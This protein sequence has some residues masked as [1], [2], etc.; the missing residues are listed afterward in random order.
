MQLG[1]I[2]QE[3]PNPIGAIGDYYEA[4]Y[5]TRTGAFEESE[6]NLEHALIYAP[7]S[8]KAKSL[9]ALSGLEERRNNFD[10]AVKLRIEASLLNNPQ[11]TLESQLGIAALMGI[12]GD[13]RY[14]AKHL[15]RFLPLAYAIGPSPVYFDF[16][17]SYA[18]ELS[19]TE[20]LQEAS[21]V[22]NKVI[23]SPYLSHFP[24]WPETEREIKQKCYSSKSIQA[25]LLLDEA[26]DNVLEFPHL[27]D[28][29]KL[30]RESE[31]RFSA[32]M[33]RFSAL[34]D[35]CQLHDFVDSILIGDMAPAR[36]AKFLLRM[37]KFEDI[38]TVQDVFH[39]MLRY[40]FINSDEFKEAETEWTEKLLQETETTDTL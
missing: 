32:E 23:K 5:L 38:K 12:Q 1:L 3:F 36:F 19:E 30:E 9:L 16:L 2:L 18:V 27:V 40:S 7:E 13:H 31:E 14:A 39:W 28:V 24:N 21:D 34:N 35:N 15:E 20:R 29:E 37:N 8:Y 33:D 6:R 22:I 17:N 11:V 10:D 26:D 25:P 4:F